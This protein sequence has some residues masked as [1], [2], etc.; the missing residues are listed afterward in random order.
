[1]TTSSIVIPRPSPAYGFMQGMRRLPPLPSTQEVNLVLATP[2][3]RAVAAYDISGA[4]QHF[5]L[6]L[7]PARSTAIGQQADIFRGVPSPSSTRAHM[8]PRPTLTTT[9]PT[10]ASP[11]TDDDTSDSSSDGSHHYGLESDEQQ[12]DVENLATYRVVEQAGYNP[13]RGNLV[14]VKHSIVD[15]LPARIMDAELY[16][17]LEE[18]FPLIHGLVCRYILGDWAEESGAFLPSPYVFR[19]VPE[20]QHGPLQQEYLRRARLENSAI[21]R[22]VL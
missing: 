11:D 14:V 4:I 9:P 16:N 22:D 20:N 18:D 21:Q 2:R 5:V 3:C 8:G 19:R 10:A 15:N 12:D 6:Y 7:D 13:I 1:M 17:V